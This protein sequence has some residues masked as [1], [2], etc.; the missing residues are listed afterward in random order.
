VWVAGLS[1]SHADSQCGTVRSNRSLLPV[2]LL[3]SLVPPLPSAPSP[4]L[5]LVCARARLL[6]RR[7]AWLAALSSPRRLTA[8]RRE[9]E[10]SRAAAAAAG[11]EK[12]QGRRG[13]RRASNCSYALGFAVCRLAEQW[14]SVVSLR[15]WRSW[16][17]SRPSAN[18]HKQPA[19]FIR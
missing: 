10:Q 16:L 9:A 7:G 14:L 3:P 13:T 1:R 17:V 4:V 12:G 2:P 8:G 18:K 11:N 5:C 15:C 6:E 19:L